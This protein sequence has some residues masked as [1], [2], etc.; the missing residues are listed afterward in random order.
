MKALSVKQPWA[1][2]IASGRKTLEIR[3]WPT[4]HRGPLLIV[5]SSQP[6]ALQLAHFR[7]RDLPCGVAIC[8]VNLVA[9]TL[10]RDLRAREGRTWLYNRAYW[11]PPDDEYAWELADVRRVAPAP[12]KGRLRLYDVADHLVQLVAA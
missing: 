11:S 8:A 5:A 7:M 9:C 2:L 3:C 10:V 4:E 6:N 1:E 12:I